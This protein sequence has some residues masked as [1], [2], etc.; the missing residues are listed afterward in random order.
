MEDK[1]VL[2]RYSYHTRKSYL[3]HFRAFLRH[4]PE[5]EPQTIG[6]LTIE[7][8]LLHLIRTNDIARATQNQVINAIKFYYEQVLGLPKQ[9]YQI[10]RPRKETKLPNVLSKSEVKR[11]LD[12]TQNLK[13]RCML[14]LTYSAGLRLSEAVNLQLSD[15]D[16]DRRTLFVRAGK[17]QKDRYVSLGRVA[18]TDLQNYQAQYKPR[19]WL[20]EGQFGDQ[21]SK[22]SL[23]AVFN[24]AKE[25]S[26][27][28]PTATFHS[29]RHSFA[30][31]CIENGYS[32]AIVKELLGHNSV[33]TTERYLH[34][35]Q[36]ALE[37]FRSPLDD[38]GNLSK[39]GEDEQE[40]T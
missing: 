23:Q 25:R 15:V 8:Y 6:R 7:Q 22:R 5:Q 14:S 21:Y 30:T 38:L 12:A 4:H 28:N 37:H 17:G 16:A 32:T 26:K 20:F 9:H 33:R 39:M 31:H 1:L 36:H 29:L 34:V 19:Y 18:L 11:L 3:A 35:A 10:K 13:H 40:K 2:C 27:V 24:Q